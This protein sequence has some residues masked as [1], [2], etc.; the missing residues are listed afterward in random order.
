MTKKIA[1]TANTALQSQTAKEKR[2]IVRVRDW[3]ITDQTAF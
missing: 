3:N 2:D 1:I